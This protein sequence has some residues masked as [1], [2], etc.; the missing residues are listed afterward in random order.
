MNKIRLVLLV[1]LMPILAA[2]GERGEVKEVNVTPEPVFEV[3]REGSFRL[4]GNPA[5]RVMNVGQNSATVKYI[6][7]SMRQ[8]RMYP[9][10]VAVSS[11]CDVEL[12]VND[13]VNSELGEEGYL[14]E[15]RNGG[16]RLSANTEQG[17]FYAF[18]TLLQLFPADVTTKRYSSVTIPECTILDYP[19]FEWRGLYLNQSG[20][21]LMLKELK[22]VVDVM[23]AYKMNRLCV[24]GVDDSVQMEEMKALRAYATEHWVSVVTDSFPCSAYSLKEGMDSARE[25]LKVV[26]EPEDWWN[27]SR[28]QADS[29]YQ[30][31]ADEGIISL[32]R[33]YDFDPVPIGTNGHVVVKVMGGQCRLLTDC[34][35]G[36]NEAEYMLLPRMVAVS[37]CLWTPREKH[38]WS[39]FR[40]KVEVEKDRLRERG[41][42]YC[43]GSFTPH[44]TARRFDEGTVN[45]AIETEVPNTYIFYTTDGTTPTRQ[46]SIYLGPVNLARGTHIKLLP[47]YKGVERDSVYEFVIK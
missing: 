7:K 2:C 11:E 32:R 8:A 38:D 45:I 41:F 30:P 13:T 4:R 18:Q 46:S 35:G 40:R 6:M 27:L 39:R 24:D 16:I 17:L 37:E 12:R 20:R 19:R 44:F 36:G 9:R 14:L 47:V 29:R 43:E 1:L 22:R 34:V 25:G 28:Y 10:L 31:K 15:V 5:V 3:Q 26:M 33:A 23:A 21:P 42:H